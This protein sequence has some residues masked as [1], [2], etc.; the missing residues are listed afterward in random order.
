MSTPAVLS[1]P[2]VEVRAPGWL[3]A[4][5]M[6]ATVM[7]V[8]DTTIANVALPHMTASLGAS[9][10]EITWVLT[11]Y[12]VAVAIATPLTGW[13]TDRLGRR[14]VF[15]GA[16]IGFTLTSLLC[17]TATSL[18]EMVLFRI[19]Q[20]VFGAVL[21]PL[22]QT[23]ILDINPREKTGQ[24]MAIYGAGIM[25]GPIIGPTLGGWLTESFN[26]RFVFLINL[27]VGLLALAGILTFLP[28]SETRERRFDLFGFAMLALAVGALQLLLDRGTAIDWFNSVEAWLY[29]G[30][31]I[32]G[33]W[34]FVVHCWTSTTPFV[35]LRIFQD[36]NFVMGLVFMFVVGMTLFS[37]LALLPPLLQRS[38][39]YPVM[40]SGLV[41]APRGVG[42]MLSMLLVGRLVGRFDPRA[43]IL[44][45][46]GVTAWS[47]WL[48]T[49]FDLSMDSRP[50]MVSGL[51][52]GFGLGF[53][54][55]PLSTLTFATIAPRFRADATSFFSLVRKVG[56]GVGISVVTAT[57]THM[58][59][60]KHEE[61]ASRL[62][63]AAPQVRFQM[64]ELLSGSPKVAALVDG[65]VTRQASMIAYVDDFLLMLVFTLA[66]LPIVMML[67][68]P[69]Q[70]QSGHGAAVPSSD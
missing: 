62:T 28:Q 24:A 54:F 9:Q 21:M 6:L 13:V 53:V 30:I 23:V 70:T 37:G 26:W 29:L 64:P 60:V 25:V 16:I 49:G 19:A 34:V 56:S 40:T 63:A 27:P 36:R 39:G 55:V 3:T 35:D 31:S 42:T 46:I 2:A 15:A 33:F 20:G 7:Q 59:S 5:V 4:A 22:A 17:G 38:M 58:I 67:R 18:P 10:D 32:S 47:L 61:L 66:K 50:V 52:Q 65:L 45:G 43:L 68:K 12:I 57:F 48:M 69:G 51:L 44:F 1:K 41:M 14:T 8:L 11:S